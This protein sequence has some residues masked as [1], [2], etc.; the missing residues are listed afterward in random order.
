MK[1]VKIF[2]LF[3]T[4][5]ILSNCATKP[6]LQ[7]GETVQI[8]KVQVTKAQQSFGS[9]NLEEDVRMKTQNAAYRVSETGVEKVLDVTITSY[10]GPSP[11]RAFLVGGSTS[12]Q[13]TIQLV[14]PKSG[15][16]TKP[17]A[18]FAGLYRQGG[19]LGA[20]AA[21]A[22]NPVDEEQRLTTLLANQIMLKVYGDDTIQKTTSRS[23]TKTAT[24]N[25]PFSYQDESRRFE[26]RNIASTNKLEREDAEE[27]ESDPFLTPMPAYCAK[28]LEAK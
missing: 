8:T 20:A 16:T 13:G 28:Y 10:V 22:I 21:A 23:A 15:A 24:A 2:G 4:A 11:G 25:Y 19:L 12:I 7:P 17:E 3:L 9:A 6:I 27:R 18:V 1:L 5:A 26:C 14:D